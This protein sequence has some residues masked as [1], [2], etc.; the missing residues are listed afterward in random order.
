[1]LIFYTERTLTNP[2]LPYQLVE[3]NDKSYFLQS[4][5]FIDFPEF[6]FNAFLPTANDI[7]VI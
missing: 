2:F 4:V 3:K 5:V 6:N 7:G 1:M